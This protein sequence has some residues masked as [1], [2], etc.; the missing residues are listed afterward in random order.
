MVA[1]SSLRFMSCWKKLLKVSKYRMVVLRMERNSQGNACVEDILLVKLQNYAFTKNIKYIKILF[2]FFFNTSHVPRLFLYLQKT[3][4][5]QM[6]YRR[7][8]GEIFCSRGCYFGG[9]SATFLQK[10]FN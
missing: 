7:R 6:G 5:N 3:L 4:E 1:N 9:S 10:Q 8:A 2:Y